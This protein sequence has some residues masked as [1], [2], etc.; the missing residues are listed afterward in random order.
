MLSDELIAEEIIRTL[1]SAIGLVLAVPVTTAIAA[2]TV[3]P[4]VHQRE[5]A[6][7]VGSPVA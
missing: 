4:A 7:P 3:A 2:A 6:A 1:A 5:G